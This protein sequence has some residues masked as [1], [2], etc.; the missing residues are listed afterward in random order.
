MV[1]TRI[2]KWMA[3]VAAAALA[4][5][6]AV[7]PV[8]GASEIAFVSES[9]ELAIGQKNYGPYRQAQGGDYVLEPQLTSYVDSVG[10]RLVK[11]ADRKLPYEFTVLN[12][13]TPNAWALPGGKIAINRGLLVEL[14]SEAEL[15]AVLGHEIVHAAARHSAQSMERGV[16]LQGALIAAGVALGGSDYQEIGMLGAG[17][18]AQLVNQKYGRDDETEADVYGMRYMVRAGY[19]PAA[20]VDLQETFVRLAEGRE[21]SW[22][23]GLFASH[24]PSGERVEANRRMVAELGN[25]GGEIG[26]QAYRRAIARIQRNK[27]AYEAFDEAQQA[28]KKKDLKTALA[29][30]DRAIA[31]EPGEATFHT[32]RGEIRAASADHEGALRDLDKAVALNPGY[33]RP[34]LVRG[35]TRRELGDSRGASSDLERS[36]AM[37]PT[38]EGYYDLGLIAQAGA[39]R[40]RAIGYFQKAATSDSEIGN[41]AGRQLARLDLQNNPSRY[42]TTRLG[43]SGDGYLLVQVDNPT[44]VAV[45]D[46]E[47]AVGQRSGSGIAQ[48]RRYDLGRT[49]AAGQ[50]AQLRTGI[51]PLS[52]EQARR[53]G[54]VVTRAQVAE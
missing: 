14:D 18:G 39:D 33:Y 32:L 1:R 21:S 47:V 29:K 50:S 53:L 12:D 4:H 30:V 48:A 19:D 13:S 54:A 6:C 3:V 42:L 51:G 20:A 8:T 38:A 9:Q 23:E 40:G 44:S 26:E 37:L 45:R 28:F 15:A 41:R 10:Q 24:P 5:G 17:L 52:T 2:W 25:P 46:V 7:N 35:I 34:L 43:L 27:P 22:L 16:F 11:V 31:I 49:L 36:V